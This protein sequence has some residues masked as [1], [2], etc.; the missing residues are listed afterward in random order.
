MPDLERGL[1]IH[2]LSN[3]PSLSTSHYVAVDNGTNTYKTTINALTTT[4]SQNAQTYAQN[5]AASASA[6]ASSATQAQTAAQGVNAAVIQATHELQTYAD[7]AQASANAAAA[8]EARTRALVTSDYAKT[9][10]SYAVGDT[11]YRSGEDTDNAM[12]YCRKTQQIH[13]ET[14]GYT[15]DA[16]DSANA[17]ESAKE[18]AESARDT[19]ESALGQISNLLSLAQ[20]TVDFST[21][22]LMY[23]RNEAYT[24][25]I[26]TV[27]GNLEWE[28][29]T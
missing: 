12:Y 17:A 23:D 24:F 9:A 3:A 5:A 4:A 19:A 1:T 28:V 20:F 18:D 2:E 6:A 21:G 8:S 26:N 29:A 10:K 27:T 16:E 15:E 11:G 13:D 25:N 14:E 22:L 7:E